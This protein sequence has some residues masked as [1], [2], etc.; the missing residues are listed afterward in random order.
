MSGYILKVN[1]TRIFDGLNVGYQRKREKKGQ[2]KIWHADNN[3]KSW[4]GY[5]NILKMNSKKYY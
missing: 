4:N 3:H 5:S 1:P 2:K